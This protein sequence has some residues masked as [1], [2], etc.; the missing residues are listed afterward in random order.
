MKER[1]VELN[2]EK[3]KLRVTELEI[4]GHRIGTNGISPSE[5]KIAAIRTFRQPQNEAEV[6][7]FLGLAN[8]MNKYIP[9]L[10]TIDEPL[11]KLLQKDAKFEWTERQSD[12]FEAIKAA[13]CRVE[14][15]GFFKME[16]RTAVIAD[17]S[18][19]GL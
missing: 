13:L 4:L 3:C 7:S 15:L 18:P 11:R 17:A 9:N 10:A 1:C 14:N 2:W 12:A 5:S 6:R 8:Y 16:D 19:V